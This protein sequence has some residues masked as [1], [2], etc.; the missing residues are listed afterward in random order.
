MLTP[1][2]DQIARATALLRNPDPDHHSPTRLAWA[3]EVLKAARG[4]RVYCD[5]LPCP[6][7]AIG[8]D[9]AHDGPAALRQRIRA[10]VIAMDLPIR[11]RPLLV[12]VN[13]GA[14]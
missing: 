2:S 14:A 5:T 12:P 11:P 13:P 9:P 8:P 4:Q 10:R 6:A 1:T 3:W 7:H